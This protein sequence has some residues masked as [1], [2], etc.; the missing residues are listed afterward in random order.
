MAF[1][2]DELLHVFRKWLRDQ[3]VYIVPTLPN[4]GDQMDEVVM[5][6]I[7][8]FCTDRKYSEKTEE[9]LLNWI[10]FRNEVYVFLEEQGIHSTE[11]NL[12]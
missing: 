8:D 2:D 6:Y 10:M 5:D 9:T 4:I 11:E 7:L 1:T 3:P 12:L